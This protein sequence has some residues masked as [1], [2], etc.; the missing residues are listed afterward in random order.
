MKVFQIFTVLTF[1]VLT[2]FAFSN[3]FC[4]FCSPAISIPND[5]ATVQKLLK[6]SCGNLGSA[7]KACGAL[8]DAVDLDSSYSKMYPNMVDLREAG[9]KVYC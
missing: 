2:T 1:V 5:W 3:P 4:K 8:V 7:G 6:I 9:C